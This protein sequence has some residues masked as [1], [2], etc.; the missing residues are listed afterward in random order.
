MHNFI[1]TYNTLS[2]LNE[3]KDPPIFFVDIKV[4]DGTLLDYIDIEKTKKISALPEDPEK[5]AIRDRNFYITKSKCL[6]T[7]TSGYAEH[8]GQPVNG[9]ALKKRLKK[10]SNVLTPE[11]ANLVLICNDCN[12]IQGQVTGKGNIPM[13]KVSVDCQNGLK[14]TTDEQQSL[15]AY[16]VKDVDSVVIPDGM[17]LPE[18]SRNWPPFREGFQYTFKCPHCTLLHKISAAA[19]KT[20]VSNSASSRAYNLALCTNCFNAEAPVKRNTWVA[21]KNSKASEFLD[22][23]IFTDDSNCLVL[24]DEGRALI[25]ELNKDN[26]GLESSDLNIIEHLKKGE[27]VDLS[28]AIKKTSRLVFPFTCTNI[29][30][31]KHNK[32]KYFKY[33]AQILNVNRGIYHGCASCRSLAAAGSSVSERLL[34]TSVEFLF[35]VTHIYNQPKIKPYHDID[36]LFNYPGKGLIGI[37]YDG[38]GFHRDPGTIEVDIQKTQAFK[39]L[40]VTFLRVRDKQCYPFDSDAAH[41]IDPLYTSLSLVGWIT[42]EKCITQIG[43]FLTDDPNWTI[44]EGKLPILKQLHKNKTLPAETAVS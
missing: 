40:G 6:P 16:L 39:K 17:V 27:S 1:Q 37:E 19:L 43:Q 11:E 31:Q 38:G 13:S 3:S 10:Y 8:G 26:T 36:I 30:C 25:L 7:C 32:G 20:R 23:T 22:K 35:D 28:N 12:K 24:T 4:G 42:Y 29:D 5:W 33:Q 34:R 2:L 9:E 41:C 14:L 15:W 21:L 44:P 18:D